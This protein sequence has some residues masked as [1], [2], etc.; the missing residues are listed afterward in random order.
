LWPDQ[1]IAPN[2]APPRRSRLFS[3]PET[4]PDR[5]F[6]P[7]KHRLTSGG[8]LMKEDKSL[9]ILVVDDHQMFREQACALLRS[10]PGFEVICEAA[11]GLEG[12]SRA[13]E[14]QPDVVVLDISMPSLGGIEA[15]G[16]IHRV[17]P[18][19]QIVFLSQHNSE[20][21]AQTALAAGALAYVTKSSASDDLIRAVKA[22]SEGK[23]FVSKLGR[24]GSND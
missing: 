12:V 17:A 5:Q 4:K 20:T 6:P 2:P 8:V 10:Q 22:V 11:N 21:I 23:K 3:V 19:S 24:W 15:A 14:L 1:N 13:A 18:K 16:R 9:R 7:K